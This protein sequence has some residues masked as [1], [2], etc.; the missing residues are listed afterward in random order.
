[1]LQIDS[2]PGFHLFNSD[3][4]DESKIT[5]ERQLDNKDDDD[6]TENAATEFLSRLKEEDEKNVIWI[7][8]LTSTINIRL[9]TTNKGEQKS[10]GGDYYNFLGQLYL[11]IQRHYH[12]FL[13]ELNETDQAVLKQMVA[14]AKENIPD[15]CLSLS[16][17]T[18]NV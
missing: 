14:S 8:V 12:Q 16:G 3:G 1:M 13:K 2:N 7:I 9:C 5:S 17:E 4:S 10:V 6:E 15:K 11:D 18:E